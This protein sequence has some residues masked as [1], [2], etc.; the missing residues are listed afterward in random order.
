MQKFGE[1]FIMLWGCVASTGTISLVKMFI[2]SK[3]IVFLWML[4][5]P[6]VTELVETK[7]GSNQAYRLFRDY[8]CLQT[9]ISLLNSNG[10]I[11]LGII[12]LNIAVFVM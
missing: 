5:V 4:H 8:I 11:P 12:P 6:N 2:F 3:N 10:I 9:I 1:G 7:H